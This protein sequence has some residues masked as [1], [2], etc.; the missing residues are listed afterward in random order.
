MMEFIQQLTAEEELEEWLKA[1]ESQ[2][3]LAA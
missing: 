2:R 1:D 3:G